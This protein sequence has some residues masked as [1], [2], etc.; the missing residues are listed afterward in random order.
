MIIRLAIIFCIS[1]FGSNLSAQIMP[2]ATELLARAS[3]KAHPRTIDV[4]ALKSGVD[5]EGRWIVVQNKVTLL[6]AETLP[7]EPLA[8]VAVKTATNEGDKTLLA[9]ALWF[10]TGSPAAVTEAKRRAFFAAR[11]MPTEAFS[12]VSLPRNSWGRLFGIARLCSVAEMRHRLEI[13]R[14]FQRCP[15]RENRFLI[16]G[17]ANHL[18]A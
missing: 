11:L 9:A 13:S 7:T 1:T 3:T 8:A 12:G 14:A 5:W 2:S 16:K 4:A 18:Q 15:H 10:R 6:Y 17:P